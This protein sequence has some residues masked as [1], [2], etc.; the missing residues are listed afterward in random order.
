MWHLKFQQC[1]VNEMSG[2]VKDTT[3]C[4][5]K[6]TTCGVNSSCRLTTKEARW[7]KSLPAI[8]KKVQQCV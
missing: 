5:V 3:A 6:D 4:I 7:W 2:V 1:V 8:T